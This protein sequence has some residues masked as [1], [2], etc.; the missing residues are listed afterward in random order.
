MVLVANCPETEPSI[1]RISTR[2]LEESP[3]VAAGDCVVV[4]AGGCVVAATGIGTTGYVEVGLER[5][6]RGSTSAPRSQ[7]SYKRIARAMSAVQIEAGPSLINRL[8]FEEREKI[9][10]DLVLEGRAHAAW[11]TLIDLQ[12]GALDELG[13][14]HGRVSDRHDLVVVAVED[15]RRDI[16]LL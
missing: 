7:T 13:R 16:N 2:P 3:V 15:E 1:E 5:T 8:R 9:F 14:Q 12:L 11:G 6:I 4:A 10:V